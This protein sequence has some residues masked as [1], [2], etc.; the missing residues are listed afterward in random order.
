MFQRR[1]VITGLGAVTPLGNDIETAFKA[2]IEGH[3]GVTTIT[4]FDASAHDARIAG[5]IKDFSLSDQIADKKEARRM[6]F[7]VQYAMAA[8]AMAISD[9]GVDL[10]KCDRDRFGVLIG[11]GIG[12]LRVMEEQHR[13]LT[14]KGPGRVSPFLIPMLIVNMAAGNVAIKW[15]LRGP[16]SCVATAC[17]TGNHAIGDAAHIIARGDADMMLAG[18][19]ESAVTP[20]G[21]A[22]F[23]SAR[24]LSTRN[25]D[26]A[27]ASRPFDNDRDGFVMGEGAGVLL[28]ESLEHALKRG[29]KIY[30]ELIG[31]GLSDDAHHMTAPPDDGNGAFRAMK[32]ALDTAQVSV[33]AV[34]YVNAHGTST[35]L[36]DKVET[37]AIKRLFG[38][39]AKKLWV[40]STKSM[41]GHLLGAAGGVEAAACMKMMQTGKVHPTINLDTPDP[42]CDLDYVPNVAREKKLKIVL[43]NSFGFG[44]VNAT[45][46]FK[47]FEG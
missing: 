7:F 23:C 46:L 10:D 21:L 34:D 17:A 8:S 38:E 16:N 4:T 9:G 33:S 45:L 43:S 19:T 47:A 22:G 25:D 15:G 2:M 28:L 40:S 14:E 39:H 5:T 6:D 29:A 27:R 36:G 30:A 42:E 32:M 41:I 1:V 11:S 31:Y 13:I 12:G 24:A 37:L 18:G 44:G 26:P 20:L 3:S 35:P